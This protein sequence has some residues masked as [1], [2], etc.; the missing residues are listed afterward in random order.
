MENNGKT[1]EE[2]SKLPQSEQ[3]QEFYKI[4]DILKN[5]KGDVYINID[6]IYEKSQ[7]FMICHE[8]AHFLYNKNNKT[9]NN[10]FNENEKK[11][12]SEVSEYSKKNPEEFVAEVYAGII[13]GAK[14]SSKV[15]KLYAKY[16]GP[17]LP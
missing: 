5:N 10:N 1:I 14:Y 9:K 4:V 15:M 12:A 17:E 8:F 11:I 6:K 3:K 2:I 13:T 7:K 16:N